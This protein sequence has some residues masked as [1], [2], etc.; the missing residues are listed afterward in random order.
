MYRSLE[1]RLVSAVREFLRRSYDLDLPR[2][3]VEQ[4]PKVELG[5]YAMPLAF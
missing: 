4:P 1:R 2:I 3:V 5:E